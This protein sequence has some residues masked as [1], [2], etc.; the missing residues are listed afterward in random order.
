MDKELKAQKKAAGKAYRKARRKSH[1]L[2]KALSFISAPLAVVL[3]ALMIVLRIFDNTVALFVGGTFWELK[4]EDQNAVY[5]ESDF[6]TEE[7]RN[8]VGYELVKQV[9]GEGAALLTNENAA[10]PLA[11]G[12]KVSLFSTSSVNLVYGGTG[13]ANVDA[14]KANDLKTACEMAGLKVNSVL[15]DFYKTGDGAQYVRNNGGFDGGAAVGEAPWSAY[16]EEV[17]SSVEE[18]SDAAIVTLSRVGGE[19]A[20]SEYQEF[21]Y[22]ALDDNE[23]EMLAGLKSLKEEGK[24]K[25]IVVLLNTSN[26]LQVDFLKDNEYGVDAALWIGGVG[27]AGTD[28]VGEILAG[29]INPS[30]SLV[31]TYCFDNYSSPAMKNFTPITYAG[32][33]AG[34]IPENAST[35]MIY[36]EGIYVGYKYYETRYEDFVMGTGNAGEYAYGDDVAFPFGYGLSY[37]TF[38]YSDMSV[39][40]DAESGDYTM[41]VTVTNTGDTAGKETVQAYVSSPYTQYDIENKVEKAS[42]SL[43]GFGKTDVLAPGASETLTIEIDGDYVASYDAYG[44]GTY[45]LDA[46]DYFFTAATDAHDAANNVLAAKGYTPENTEGRMDTEGKADLVAV[47]NNPKLDTT[48]YAVSDNGTEIKNQLS[49]A[50]P[51]LNEGVEE[52]VTFVSR[53]DWM[54]TMPTDKALILTL[55][56]SLKEALQDVQYDPA[57]YEEVPMPTLG[58]KNG[59]TLYDMIGLDYDDPQWEKL[60]DQLTFKEMVNLIGDSFHWTMPVKSVEA[61][62]TRDENGPQGLTV[63]LFGSGLG[64]NTTALTSEDVLAATFN[65][66][67]VYEMGNMV[68]NDCLAANVAVLYGPG[69]NTHRSP[70]GGRNFE[71]YSEDGV[72]ASEIGEAEVRGIEEKGVHVVIKHFALNDCEQDRIGLGVWLTEQAAREVYLRAFQGALEGSQA[73][74]NGV[75]MAYTRWGTQWAGANAGLVKGIL[76][77]E[78][79]CNGKQITDNVLTT[80]VNGVDGVMGGTTSFDSMMSFYIINNGNGQGRLPEYKN[81]PVV[82]SAMRE[83]AHHN[84]YAT[85]NSCGMNGVGPDTEIKLTKPTEIKL[86][87]GLSAFFS[88]L[89]VV[90]VVLWIVKSVKF[91][92]SEAYAT[93]QEFKKSLK[94]S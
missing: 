90:S 9:E 63:T 32:Y 37:T 85:A 1:G 27:I 3:V 44:A 56:E 13:S 46:G 70:Y 16:T 88:L 36:Q 45:I 50:D 64:V 2:W 71:Y 14:S 8:A 34:M 68:G 76:N 65:R 29:K 89:F 84:L 73:G 38:D 93:Y 4:N 55:T 19:G 86:A 22:L 51:N 48:T 18:Y 41:K 30:G 94:K 87:N 61:P 58:A 23:K 74:G 20:D 26:P 62:G 5:F 83:A 6:E 59:L 53:N 81:D 69:A 78:W 40:Y 49:N 92:K 15:W 66:D 21:N 31:D 80:Y 7:E 79:G 77:G 25:K 75:M 33:E 17:L 12:A 91:R 11:E 60:L 43:V 82:V 67:L 54:G 47:W 42:V 10:L 35:Y 39:S 28:A 57:D 24:I 72:L 52:E